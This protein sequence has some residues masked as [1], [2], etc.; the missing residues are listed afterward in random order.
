[1]GNLHCNLNAWSN[2]NRNG[3]R[4]PNIGIPENN[5]EVEYYEVVLLALSRL[6]WVIRLIKFAKSETCTKN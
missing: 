5:F 1:M 3:D 4:Y 2:V 6:F